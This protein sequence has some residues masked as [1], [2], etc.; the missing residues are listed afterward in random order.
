MVARSGDRCTKDLST[1]WAFKVFNRRAL[2]DHSGTRGRRSGLLL[3]RHFSLL[4][5]CERSERNSLHRIGLQRGP[6]SSMSPMQS[7]VCHWDRD[8]RIRKNL[9]KDAT[10]GRAPTV[11]AQRLKLLFESKP[12]STFFKRNSSLAI[13]MVR[14]FSR[15]GLANG[16]ALAASLRCARGAAAPCHRDTGDSESD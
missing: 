5:T 6:G 7:S 2:P 3:D 9:H 13:R 12:I 11:A 4:Q 15:L 16:T 1:D 14:Y 10:V 8:K